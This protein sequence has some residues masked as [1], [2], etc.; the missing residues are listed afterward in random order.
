MAQ[1][2]PHSI[3]PQQIRALAVDPAAQAHTQTPKSNLWMERRNWLIHA[4]L[5]PVSS[6][7]AP[8]SRM[9]GAHTGDRYCMLL[10]LQTGCSG[11]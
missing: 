7:P 5:L 6:Q 11:R 2:V 9:A 8:T 10:T 4:I 1:V 3:A